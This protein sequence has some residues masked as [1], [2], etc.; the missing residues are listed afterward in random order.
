MRVPFVLNVRVSQEASCV[1]CA[2]GSGGGRGVSHGARS[3]SGELRQ[4]QRGAAAGARPLPACP[5]FLGVVGPWHEAREERPARWPGV[6]G[7]GLALPATSLYVCVITRAARSLAAV[8]DP[9][10]SFIIS[11]LRA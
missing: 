2:L 11:G 6:E 10:S 3:R 4:Q 5:G 7:A 8:F 1:E 9:L